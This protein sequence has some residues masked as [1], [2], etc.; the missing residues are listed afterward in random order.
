M[1]SYIF[2]LITCAVI[3]LMI[4]ISGYKVTAQPSF[5]TEYKCLGDNY[6]TP[7]QF[8]VNL[9]EFLSSL[10]SNITASDRK[11]FNSGT[12]NNLD[13][14]YG[15]LL[16][17]GDVTQET[18]KICAE[19]A[20][21]ELT[22]RCPNTKEYIA[23]YTHCMLRYS[24]RNIF[25]K[26]F[27]DIAAQF[28]KGLARIATT[29]ANRNQTLLFATGEIDYSS[30][31]KIY[32]LVQCTTDISISDCNDCLMGAIG[33]ISDCCYGRKGGIV[34]R[35]SCNVRYEPYPFYDYKQETNPGPLPSSP[36]PKPNVTATTGGTEKDDKSSS[37]I[38]LQKRT[39]I[40]SVR[41]QESSKAVL[42]I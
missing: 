38:V 30:V 6:T 3:I 29:N 17:R 18:C 7:S 5:K 20:I 28:M 31:N 13:K 36:P 34:L 11:F 26:E 32:V 22:E 14:V 37:N 19:T 33:N 23:F 8:Q 42:E 39:T 21:S 25:S 35:P 15:I 16:C 41:S 40:L 4:H 27:N 24:D 12:G 1:S 9:N 10:S 2:R